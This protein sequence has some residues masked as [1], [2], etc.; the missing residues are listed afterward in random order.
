M[1]L[2]VSFFLLTSLFAGCTSNKTSGDNRVRS[3]TAKVSKTI[4]GGVSRHWVGDWERRSRHN[5]ASLEIKSITND[6]IEFKLSAVNG[7]NT[8]ELE[9]MAAIT[10]TAA[11]FLSYDDTDTCIVRFELSGDSIITITQ[12][13]FCPAGA[14]VVYSGRYTNN[15][16]KNRRDEPD[17][18][19]LSLGVFSTEMQDS[20]FRALVGEH[21]SRFVISTQVTSEDA[22][23][24]GWNTTVR[25]SGVRGLFTIME[26]IVM[27]DSSNNIWAAVLDNEKVRYFTTD[28]SAKRRLPKTIDNWRQ[29]FKEY[30]I[31]Y[32]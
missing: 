23:L 25:S 2:S 3:D 8:G 4:G 26:N 7:A 15:G 28:K 31:V 19:M 17:E 27:L 6:S 11:K 9:G 13:G 12:E 10:G 30:P 18:S 32:E 24:D 29:R 5:E 22:D 21:Y 14:G 1:K 16:K 20:V